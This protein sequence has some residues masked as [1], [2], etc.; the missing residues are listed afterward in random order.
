MK[1]FKYIS[2]TVV[3][4]IDE[5][6]LSRVSGLATVLVPE[7]ATIDAADM[8]DNNAQIN[9][10]IAALEAANP[11]THRTMR[12]FILGVSTSV[13]AAQGLTQAQLLNPSDAHYSHAFAAFAAV[14]AQAVALRAQKT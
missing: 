8:P 7:G 11:I 14:D 10:E 4:V 2:E 9:S 5:D 6:G 13:A 1:T 3:A 12:E